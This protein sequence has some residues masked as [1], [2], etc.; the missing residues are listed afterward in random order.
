MSAPLKAK[1]R[2]SDDDIYDAPTDPPQRTLVNAAPSGAAWSAGPSIAELA[3]DVAGLNR[4]SDEPPAFD[5]LQEQPV[6]APRA[7]SPV[8]AEA[9]QTADPELTKLEQLVARGAWE[10]LA[11]L[12]HDPERPAL[13]RLMHVIALRETIPTDATG[14]GK[15]TQDAIV[16]LAELLGLASSS[17]T[18]LMLTKRLLRRNPVWTRAA[19]TTGVS[20]GIVIVGLLVGG[21]LGWLL[22]RFVL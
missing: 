8:P 16:A 19:P 20:A 14:T 15:L 7:N 2:F 22:T 12:G 5:E 4:Y 18:A 11:K 1:P 13:H 6:S 10:E 17:P 21:G 3:R 9:A